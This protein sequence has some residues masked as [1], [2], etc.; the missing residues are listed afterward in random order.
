MASAHLTAKA[1][2]DPSATVG[3]WE[4]NAK[5]QQCGNPTEFE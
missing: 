1:G 3:F 5:F 2:Y 4:G